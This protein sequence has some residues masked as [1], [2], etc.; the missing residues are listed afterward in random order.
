MRYYEVH[1]PGR[2]EPALTSNVRRLRDLPEG[3]QIHAISTFIDEYGYQAIPGESASRLYER[4]VEL[5]R[6]AEKD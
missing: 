5:I 3:T 6:I 2:S 1:L 4:I